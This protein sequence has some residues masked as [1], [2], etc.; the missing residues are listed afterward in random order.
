MRT[1]LLNVVNIGVTKK[2]YMGVA[3]NRMLYRL[4]MNTDKIETI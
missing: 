4:V 2:N 1:S 3:H